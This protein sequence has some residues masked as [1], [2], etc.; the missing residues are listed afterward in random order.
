ML[1]WPT[2]HFSYLHLA[3]TKQPYHTKI[4]ENIFST[5]NVIWW[6]GRLWLLL[7]K[8]LF[9]TWRAI[10]RIWHPS[11][12]FVSD[13]R[14]TSILSNVNIHSDSQIDMHVWRMSSQ[15]Q[16]RVW[17][18]A[19]SLSCFPLACLVK[20]YLHISL[21]FICCQLIHGICNDCTRPPLSLWAFR[22]CVNYNLT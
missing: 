5:L 13:S 20:S 12:R 11:L 9:P 15:N 14:H 22:C 10:W 19:L 2:T 17:F 4:E 1:S 3:K 7:I 18:Y 16:L 21:L 8:W 6:N